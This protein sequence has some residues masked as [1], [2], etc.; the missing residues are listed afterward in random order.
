MV[1]NINTKE[2]EFIQRSLSIDNLSI[3]LGSGFSKDFGGPTLSDISK[4][5]VPELRKID[6][7]DEQVNSWIKEDLESESRDIERFLDRLY[8]RRAYNRLSKKDDTISQKYIQLTQSKIIELCTFKPIFEK[9]P[10]L[11]S[12]LDTLVCRKAGL[13]RSN[14]STLNYD[15]LVELC[16][17]QLG[18]LLNDGFDGALERWFNPAQFDLDFYYPSGVVGDKPIRCERII[19]Y[20]KLHGSVNWKLDGTRIK[21]QV[22]GDGDVVIYPN[23]GK[24]ETALASPYFENFKRFTDSIKRPRSVLIVMGYAFRDVHVNQLIGQ[25]IEQPAFHLISVNPDEANIKQVEWYTRFTNRIHT[26]PVGVAEFAEKWLPSN[27]SG[28][29]DEIKRMEES[30]GI[31]S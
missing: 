19:N 23:F 1:T 18:I 8:L 11:F 16:T 9:L 17:D 28:F 7:G 25:A 14:I 13:A 6:S 31:I 4:L 20:Y 5:L 22:A 27:E 24:Y 29:G 12:L 3:L 2:K 15:V 10:P 21:K 26:I 30:F